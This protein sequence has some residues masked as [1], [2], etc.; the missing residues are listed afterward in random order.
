MEQ[1][2]GQSKRQQIIEAAQEAWKTAKQFGQKRA[3]F[4]VGKE[5]WSI[6]TKQRKI[7]FEG[8]VA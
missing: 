2:E 3:H 1:T 7:H 4:V 6:S 8:Y 5:S